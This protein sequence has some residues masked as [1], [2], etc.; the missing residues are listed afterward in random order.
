MRK[1]MRDRKRVGR[2]L[3]FVGSIPVHGD[4]LAEAGVRH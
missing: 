4:Q 3:D 2:N 1:N